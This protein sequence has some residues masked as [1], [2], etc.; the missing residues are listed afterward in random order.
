MRL[1]IRLVLV[2]VF[3][4]GFSA[5]N[6]IGLTAHDACYQLASSASSIEG[7]MIGDLSEEFEVGSP[8]KMLSESILNPPV[9]VLKLANPTANLDH[10]QS[11][12]YQNRSDLYSLKLAFLI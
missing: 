6:A 8:S 10:C 2:I 3:A 11:N 5:S 7:P 12:R 1:L 4:A 9:E